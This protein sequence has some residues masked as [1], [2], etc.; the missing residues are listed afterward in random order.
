MTRADVHSCGAHC[1]S[2]TDPHLPS[3]S[4]WSTQRPC[5]HQRHPVGPREGGRLGTQGEEALSEGGGWLRPQCSGRHSAVFSQ[6]LL[7]GVSLR[8]RDAWSRA[9]GLISGSQAN[10]TQVSL[11]LPRLSISIKDSGS[12]SLQA[13]TSHLLAEPPAPSALPTLA[14]HTPHPILSSACT[15][16]LSSGCLCDQLPIGRRP[17][18]L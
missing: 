1:F 7:A 8:R 12:V 6:C 14:V 15:S 18:L 10:V 9:L 2:S 17:S 4:S 11:N 13:G 3:G 16:S 5:F